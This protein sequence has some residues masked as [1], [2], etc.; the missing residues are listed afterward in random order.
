MLPL[1]IERRLKQILGLSER[2]QAEQR[3]Y[4]LGCWV[5]CDFWCSGENEIM[6]KGRHTSLETRERKSKHTCAEESAETGKWLRKQENEE[7]SP[8]WLICRDRPSKHSHNEVFQRCIFLFVHG[9]RQ[10]W[11]TKFKNDKGPALGRHLAFIDARTLYVFTLQLIKDTHDIINAHRLPSAI[12]TALAVRDFGHAAHRSG[13][14]TRRQ[15]ATCRG[16][17]RSP[18]RQH[19]CAASIAAPTTTTAA[20]SPRRPRT[21]ERHRPGPHS[22]SKV[23]IK[24]LYCT[25]LVLHR[26]N[27]VR[28]GRNETR[29]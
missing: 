13:H 6:G 12:S 21:R 25:V 22:N 27:T 28:T 7:P 11:C 10:P 24:K 15:S 26:Y 4:F 14:A 16:A 20:P 2:L 1:Q 19:P 3:V 29:D 17:A 9:T 8:V 23:K 5:D 18:L